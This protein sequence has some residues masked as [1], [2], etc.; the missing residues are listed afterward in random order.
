MQ[1][2]LGSA[3][4]ACV[5]GKYKAVTGAATCTHCEVNT[6]YATVGAT[7]ANTCRACGQNSQSPSG[8]VA[9]TNCICNLGYTGPKRRECSAC[10]AGKFK[11]AT[12]AELPTA[13]PASSLIPWAVKQKQ[14]AGPVL[15]FRPLQQAKKS[16]SATP[17]T[18][19]ALVMLV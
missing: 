4:I 8:S 1:Q 14:S 16:V 5:A 10:T 3:C 2:V 17:V 6:F 19:D 7:S 18:L 13:P 12:G 11:P 15:E 9:F